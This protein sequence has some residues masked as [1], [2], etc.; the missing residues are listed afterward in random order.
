MR[1]RIASPLGAS[2][3]DV[4]FDAN[5]KLVESAEGGSGNI[6]EDKSSAINEGAGLECAGNGGGGGGGGRSPVGGAAL[7]GG[8]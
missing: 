1:L 7:G 2:K 8:I 6:S 3:V 4:L 5:K